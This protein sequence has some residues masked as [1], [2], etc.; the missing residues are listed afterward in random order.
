MRVVKPRPRTEQTPEPASAQ[1]T[2]R[3]LHARVRHHYYTYMPNKKRHRVLVWVVFLLLVGIVAAQMLYPPDRALPLTRISGQSVVWHDHESLAQQLNQRF[4]DTRLRLKVGSDTAVTVSAAQAGAEPDV[5]AMIERLVDYPFWQR[6]IPLSILFHATNLTQADAFYTDIVLTKFSEQQAKALS[7]PPT[8]AR[9]AI[10]NGALIATSEKR[11]SIVAASAVHR[12]IA[13]A[14]LRLG[15][16]I[17]VE[18]PSRREQPEQT[19][20]DLQAVRRQAEAA[21]G[22]TLTIT[23]RER[24]FTPDAAMIASWLVIGS[25]DKKLP[26]LQLDAA[27]FGSYV[28][29]IDKQAGTPAGMTNINL[30]NGRESGRTEGAKGSAVDRPPLESAVRG[31]LL[32]GEGALP[33]AA[34]FVDVAPKIMYDNKYTA[35]QE[36]LQAYATDTSRRLNVRIV[37]RQLD[38]ERW[39]VSARG[40]ESIPSAS[41]YKLF[42]AKWL[43]GQMDHGKVGWNDPMLDTTVSGCF[44]RMTIASTNPCALSWLAQVGRENMNQYVYGL[45]FSR[46]TSFTEPD[47]TH[48][49]ANDLT[50]FMIGLHDGSMVGGA[51]RDRLLR[52]LS[53]HPYRYGIPTGSRGQVWDKVGFLWDYIHDTAIVRHPKGTYVMTIMTKGHSYAT[54]ASLTREMERI[55]Y[56]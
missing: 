14:E 19:A 30:V 9:L 7:F 53:V 22:R 5:A 56:P 28:D 47:A 31:W 34:T 42:V 41:T 45:G 52:S 54:I 24:T 40:D 16:T 51:H 38:G 48:S 23:A 55:M 25:D 18:I 44:D 36:G 49:T 4:R 20:N 2:R 17:S 21:L 8:N 33:L 3:P 6:F 37:V 1:S 32:G 35:T 10:E 39:A 29:E 27:K 15:E 11:G 43:F 12:A 13:D 50:K 46:G 26:V